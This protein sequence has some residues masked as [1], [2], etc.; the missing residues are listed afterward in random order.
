M[1]ADELT[2]GGDECAGYE[3]LEEAFAALGMDADAYAVAQSLVGLTIPAAGDAS[4][5]TAVAQCSVPAAVAH[6]AAV[7]QPDDERAHAATVRIQAAIRGS[8]V[9]LGFAEACT[10]YFGASSPPNA[11]GKPPPANMCFR[12]IHGGRRTF[13]FACCAHAAL[14]IPL[15]LSEAL[16]IFPHKIHNS[17]GHAATSGVA[18]GNRQASGCTDVTEQQQKRIKG[19]A[20]R[21]GAAAAA[22]T[23]LRLAR[24]AAIE[25]KSRVSMYR[26]VLYCNHSRALRDAEDADDV[27]ARPKADAQGVCAALRV[28]WLHPIFRKEAVQAAFEPFGVI[29]Q[30]QMCPGEKWM[31]PPEV[32]T[33][34]STTTTTQSSPTCTATS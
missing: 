4:A 18:L 19:A 24:E 11:Q 3:T 7:A 5:V 1:S 27:H 34:S 9:R 12:R 21:K 10:L 2:N 25:A 33:P 28:C 31:H 8:L 6:G 17:P 26:G 16:A 22:A 14:A 30:V 29:K 32:T 15:T 13:D 23:Q 20:A